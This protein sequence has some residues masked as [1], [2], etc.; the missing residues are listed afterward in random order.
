MSCQSKKLIISVIIFL[1]DLVLHCSK[2][3]HIYSHLNADFFCYLKH[4]TYFIQLI[5]INHPKCL[6]SL[7]LHI[8]RITKIIVEKARKHRTATVTAFQQSV[9]M[10]FIRATTSTND[11]P[12]TWERSKVGAPKMTPNG[13]YITHDHLLLTWSVILKAQRFSN[14]NLV[15]L[16]LLWMIFLAVCLSWFKICPK[17]IDNRARYNYI[18]IVT[19]WN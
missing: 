10:V 1:T 14:I 3:L 4:I 17:R 7:Y 18:K 19:K 8:I 6:I 9:T 16:K 15:S 11:C 13:F 5:S 2:N 12:F